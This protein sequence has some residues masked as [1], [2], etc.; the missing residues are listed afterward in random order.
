M[1]VDMAKNLYIVTGAPGAGK[2]TALNEFLKLNT[3]Y[4]GFDV[5]WLLASATVLANKSVVADASTWK[6][7]RQIW[8]SVLGAVLNNNKVPVL[9]AA[10][11][12]K[13]ITELDIPE[14]V[15]IH[16]LLLDCSE[17]VRRTRLDSRSSMSADDVSGALDD[18]LALRTEIMNTIM[19]DCISAE[20]IAQQIEAWM[21][22]VERGEV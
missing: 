8:I 17:E 14:G 18:A 16:W 1:K 22:K 5:D 21:T 9:F 11:N 2:S 15:T 4:L 19:T 7:F 13:D 20:E 3:N 12:N 6:P 10:V